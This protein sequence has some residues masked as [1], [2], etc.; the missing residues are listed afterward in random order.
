MISA[1]LGNGPVAQLCAAA[2]DEERRRLALA[3]AAEEESRWQEKRLARLVDSFAAA[4]GRAHTARL[5]LNGYHTHRRQ[6]RVRRG[7]IAPTL[8]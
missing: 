5:L 7:P 1:Y 8:G 2:E 3:W 6:W 4:V